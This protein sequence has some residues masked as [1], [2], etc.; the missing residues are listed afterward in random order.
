MKKTL[1]W[2]KTRKKKSRKLQSRKHTQYFNLS[3]TSLLFEFPRSSISLMS[4]TRHSFKNKRMVKIP[5][6]KTILF[7]TDT[8]ISKRMSLIHSKQKSAR[9]CRGMNH[10]GNCARASKES[11]SLTANSGRKT[12]DQLNVCAKDIWLKLQDVFE[13]YAD[14]D[15]SKKSRYG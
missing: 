4:S 8:E 2:T 3:K 9:F 13:F 12:N 5:T 14:L 10:G 1:T 7:T 6:P 11:V 15:D